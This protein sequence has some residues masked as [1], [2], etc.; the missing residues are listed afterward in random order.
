MSEKN[1]II[2]SHIIIITIFQ[3]L[4]YLFEI[5]CIAGLC[6]YISFL[7]YPASDSEYFISIL[8]RF[9]LFYGLYQIAIFVV[10]NN[11]NDIQADEYL[12]LYTACEHALLACK[13]NDEKSKDLLIRTIENKQLSSTTFNDISVRECYI[14]L[15]TCIKE[16][17][18]P[19]IESL[20]ITSNHNYEMSNL[21]WR[22]SILLRLF[23]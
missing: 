13:Y 20:K 19:A 23:K 17:N 6:T 2:K 1:K 9:A 14:N 3:I 4:L 12:A 8:E 5:I 18:I 22:F 10:F 21:Q 7:I 16:C 11:I 15:I